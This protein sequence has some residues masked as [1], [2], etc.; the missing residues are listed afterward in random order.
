MKKHEIIKILEEKLCSEMD[1][2]FVFNNETGY[3]E[4]AFFFSSI[5]K[6]REF[7]REIRYHKVKDDDEVNMIKLYIEKEGCEEK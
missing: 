5:E 6:Q 7:E 1:Y 3:F 4:G 2:D